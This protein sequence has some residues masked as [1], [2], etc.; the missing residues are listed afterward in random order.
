MERQQE[1]SVV[2]D[3]VAGTITVTLKDGGFGDNDGLVNGEI[4]DPA[5]PGFDSF[6]HLPNVDVVTLLPTIVDALNALKVAVG[7]TPL[8]SDYDVDNSG[9]VDISDVM[10]ILRKSINLL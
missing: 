5:A 6:A 3:K 9:E 2:F 1:D 8:N 4:T 7:I 10:L